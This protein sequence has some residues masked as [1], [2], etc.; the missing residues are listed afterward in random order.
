MF[1]AIARPRQENFRTLGQQHATPYSGVVNFLT[2]AG[3]RHDKPL[4]LL[5]N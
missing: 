2:G 4:N 3:R 1:L 5:L